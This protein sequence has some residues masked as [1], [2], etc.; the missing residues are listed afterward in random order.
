MVAT[1]SFS[2]SGSQAT[3][4]T[5]HQHHRPFHPGPSQHPISS[6]SPHFLAVLLNIRDHTG[7]KSH[8]PSQETL[9]GAFLEWMGMDG[10]GGIIIHSYM[11]WI[12][13]PHSR[14]GLHQSV[15]LHPI[16]LLYIII[17]HQFPLVIRAKPQPPLFSSTNQW[18]K[19]FGFTTTIW[20]VSWH[21]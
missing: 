16:I 19:K 15:S 2:R 3:S 13:N 7:Y 9:T 12:M 17:Y 20:E 11:K 5:R 1:N 4:L 10:N 6:F 8:L 21:P 18:E 14:S